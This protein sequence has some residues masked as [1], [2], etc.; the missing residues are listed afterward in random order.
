[1]SNYYIKLL[2][3]VVYKNPNTLD[4]AKSLNPDT[5]EQPKINSTKY[6]WSDIIGNRN[7]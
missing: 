1:M 3:Y 2:L 4:A 5:I 7:Y 6:L